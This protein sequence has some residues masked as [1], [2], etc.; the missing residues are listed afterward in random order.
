MDSYWIDII[1]GDEL[2]DQALT[3]NT[4]EIS[5]P[6]KKKKKQTKRD[7]F[8]AA[9]RKLAKLIIKNKFKYNGKSTN[10]SFK[11]ALKG[12][13]NM[14]CALFITWALQFAHIL[15]FNKRIWGGYTLHGSG[16]KIIKRKCKIY[17]INKKTKHMFKKLRVGDIVTYQ[18][19]DSKH[20]KVHTMAYAG[21]K[22]FFTGGSS[23]MKVKKL[24]RRRKSYDNMPIRLLIRIK[25]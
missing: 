19:G 23:D 9:L 22:K 21:H 24:C 6:K 18:W 2:S 14:N 1:G 20:N 11:K 8:V 4:Q 13:R 12:N 10:V 15:P 25:N 17:R 7:K 5:K 16:A 3:N